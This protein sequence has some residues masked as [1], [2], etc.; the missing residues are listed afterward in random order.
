LLALFLIWRDGD[1]FLLMLPRD[2]L[3]V[4]LKKLSMYVLRAKVKLS[5][6][7]ELKVLS[8]FASGAVAPAPT[9]ADSPRLRLATIHRWDPG[10]PA[11]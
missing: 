6:A 4:I 7:A 10:H 5:D 3:P 1:D 11:G 2:I 9:F 8:G